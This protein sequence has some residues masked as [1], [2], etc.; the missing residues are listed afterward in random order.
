MAIVRGAAQSNLFDSF[1]QYNIQFR[2]CMANDPLMSWSNIDDFNYKGGC[3]KSFCKYANTCMA[4]KAVH[5]LVKC[6]RSCP[7]SVAPVWK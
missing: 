6:T 5:P 7:Q 3:F 1:Y 4:C 2:L